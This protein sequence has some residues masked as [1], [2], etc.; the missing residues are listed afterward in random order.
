MAQRFDVVWREVDNQG[1]NIAFHVRNQ[2]TI[3]IHRVELQR[4]IELITNGDIQVL[5]EGRTGQLGV[6]W[7]EEGT[8]RTHADIDPTESL[9]SVPIYPNR[10]AMRRRAT[11]RAF[12]LSTAAI[13][14]RPDCA[15][16]RGERARTFSGQQPSAPGLP[17]KHQVLNLA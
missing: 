17:F 10:F 2:A 3:E 14:A 5:V 6:C 1:T 9:E 12:H 8:L 7:P 15:L 4:L 11:R 13:T 16:S